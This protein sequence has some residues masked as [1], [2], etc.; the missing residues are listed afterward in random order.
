MFSDPELITLVVRL[1]SETIDS[2]TVKMAADAG[3][4]DGNGSWCCGSCD[5]GSCGCGSCDS[6]S[7]D[8]GSC[9][10][11][12][13]GCGS[14]DCGSVVDD[15][16]VK[17]DDKSAVMIG[18]DEE[19][20]CGSCVDSVSNVDSNSG[21]NDWKFSSSVSSE[22]KSDWIWRW[23]P[24]ISTTSSR[25]VWVRSSKSSNGFCWLH[26]IIIRIAIL[27][28]KVSWAGVI[29][30]VLTR[31][32]AIRQATNEIEVKL[33]DTI[34]A[35]DDKKFAG[36]DIDSVVDGAVVGVV[37]GVVDVDGNS[38]NKCSAVDDEKGT[39][40]DVV[41]DVSNVEMTSI[42]LYIFFSSLVNLIGLIF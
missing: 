24:I 7:C 9:G 4:E 18:D 29:K 38:V 22:E 40:A 34:D 23:P 11:G 32:K 28:N 15:D 27:M 26:L 20:V 3:E 42:S 16:D 37:D 35:V 6:G 10:C 39:E 17:E 14:C 1:R 8:C 21:W 41:E 5:C 31:I 2:V 30:P 25:I 13:C 36:D 33:P 19:E 12:S